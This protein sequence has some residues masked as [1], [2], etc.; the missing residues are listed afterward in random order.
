MASLDYSKAFDILNH[1]ILLNKLSI[2]GL[3]ALSRSWFQSY[4][5]DRHQRI[6]YNGALSDCKLVMY[7]VPQGS[8]LSP[9]LFIIYVDELLLKLP[10]STA[11]AYVDD[12]T[13]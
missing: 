12:I 2:I 9:T 3:F 4:L 6:K 10:D 13:F 7:G 11:L 5:E 8:S 1:Q